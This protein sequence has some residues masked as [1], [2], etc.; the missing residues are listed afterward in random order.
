MSQKKLITPDQ[1]KFFLERFD[2]DRMTSQ[3]ERVWQKIF[4]HLDSVQ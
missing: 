1:K 3:D 2:W 4:E